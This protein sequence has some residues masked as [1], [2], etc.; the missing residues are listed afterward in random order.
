MIGLIRARVSETIID[1]IR[2]AGSRTEGAIAGIACRIG[3]RKISARRHHG[4]ALLHRQRI[5]VARI[6]RDDKVLAA[7]VKGVG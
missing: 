3:D 6:G 2:P 5:P 4:G 7:L 1:G